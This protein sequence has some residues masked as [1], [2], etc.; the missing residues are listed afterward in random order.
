M[1][2]A[3][4]TQLALSM[5]AGG[6]TKNAIAQ[7]ETAVSL[8]D[9]LTRSDALLILLQLKEGNIDQAAAAATALTQREPKNPMGFNLLGVVQPGEER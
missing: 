9:K 6:E 5:V 2:A 1:S 4:R 3:L 8:D 7:L